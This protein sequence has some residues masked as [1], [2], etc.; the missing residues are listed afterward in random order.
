MKLLTER[1]KT[2]LATLEEQLK[3]G[4]KPRKNGKM[5]SDYPQED[6]LVDKDKKP[7]AIKLSEKDRTRISKEIEKLKTL[8][9]VV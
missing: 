2:V 4:D 9:K 8:T 7:Y 5:F 1:R 6:V 3:R